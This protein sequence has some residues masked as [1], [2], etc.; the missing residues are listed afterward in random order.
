M[1]VCVPVYVHVSVCV[2]GGGGGGGEPS[3]V[4][5]GLFIG[6]M[7]EMSTSLTLH[8]NKKLVRSASGIGI[9]QGPFACAQWS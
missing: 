5:I 7:A 1:C 6:L 2:G 4:T 9:E 3:H 8:D